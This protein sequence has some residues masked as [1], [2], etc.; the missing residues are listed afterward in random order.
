[1]VDGNDGRLIGTVDS[2]G[3]LVVGTVP[4]NKEGGCA[5]S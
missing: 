1:M 5:M 2:G 4:I 3:R